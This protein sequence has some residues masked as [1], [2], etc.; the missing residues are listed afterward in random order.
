MQINFLENEKGKSQK[1]K[2]EAQKEELKFSKPQTNGSSIL[3]P[4][5]KK[6]E[7]SFFKKIFNY[8]RK[9][10]QPAKAKLNTSDISHSRA[11]ILDFINKEKQ[12]PA[13][14]IK[15]PPHPKH[16]LDFQKL[17]HE[18]NKSEEKPIL[19]KEK[20]ETPKKKNGSFWKKLFSKPKTSLPETPKIESV[21]PIKT[22]FSH[23]KFSS[24]LKPQDKKPRP[25]K[26][27]FRSLFSFSPKKD[28]KDDKKDVHQKTNPATK[29]LDDIKRVEKAPAPKI[30]KP[31]KQAEPKISEIENPDV[32]ESNLIKGGDD[33]DFDWGRNISFSL[34]SVILASAILGFSYWGLNIWGDKKIQESKASTEEAE[35][36]R[37]ELKQVKERAGEAM[38]FRDQVK[39]VNTMLDNHVYWTNFFK[40]LEDNTLSQVYYTGGF[41]GDISG[42]YRF[43]AL[44]DSY[45][46]IE[47]QVEQFVLQSEVLSAGANAGELVVDRE[48][49][50]SSV[51]FELDLNL[52][53]SVFQEEHE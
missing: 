38:K 45:G 13:N 33:A 30:E 32:L 49:G 6:E 4:L 46:L 50:S 37:V 35:K 12:A 14:P 41:S 36:I 18:K 24:D 15:Q 23:T 20:K 43:S 19:E 29:N 52:K 1:N 22:D 16:T 31:E 27:S 25:D 26:V 42:Q 47:A 34:L 39:L 10:F 40:F 48:T 9:D 8:F 11:E 17:K 21:K 28:N 5:P 44:T 7:P 53:P 3:A 51:K 2:T